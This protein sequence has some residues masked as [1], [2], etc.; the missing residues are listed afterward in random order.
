MRAANQPVSWWGWHWEPPVP[1]S[2]V[3]IL[4]AGNMPPR[5]AAMFWLAMERGASLIVAADPPSAGKTATLTALLSLTSPETVAYFTRGAGETF[6]LPPRTDA[7]PT[8]ILVNEMSD[9][10]PVYSWDG[11]ARRAFELLAEGYSLATTV[12]ANTVDEV[13][14]ILRDEIRVPAEQIAG[15]TFIAPLHLD[16]DQEAGQLRRRVRE[17]A[18]I[19]PGAGG[20]VAYRSIVRWD[21]DTDTFAILESTED[22]Q[23]LARWCGLV[24]EALL[25]EIE[26]REAFFQ[27]LLAKGTSS[28]P[29]VNAAIERFYAAEVRPRPDGRP[30][31]RRPA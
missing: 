22:R 20:D 29:E 13:I 14:A 26:R 16:R 6:A 27:R 12:H 4:Q 17:V 23:A 5:L 18:F 21:R 30:P 31:G 9:H 19:Q 10:L 3:Q 25:A 1:L 8:Y 24:P 11:Y 28:I 15:L 7:H 2:I